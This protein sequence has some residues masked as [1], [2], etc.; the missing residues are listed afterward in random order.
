MIYS[1]F[2]RAFQL[3]MKAGNYFLGYRMPEYI[4]GAGC[5]K[6]LPAMILEKGVDNVL[7]VTD[8]GIL[9][10]GLTDSLEEAMKEAGLNYTIFSELQPNPTDENIEAGFKVFKDSGCKGIIAFGGGSSMDCAKGIAAKDA[11]PDKTVAQL[12]GIL[13]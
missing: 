10:L 1:I 7:L 8:K 11:H 4:E 12:Q 13:K 6:Q 5:I 3:G 9:G 2:D